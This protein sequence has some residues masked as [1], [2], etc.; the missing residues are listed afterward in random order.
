[1]EVG[2]QSFSCYYWSSVLHLDHEGL[3]GQATY[4]ENSLLLVVE[5][6]AKS[7][8]RQQ[9]GR[10]GNI[11]AI[12]FSQ[13]SLRKHMQTVYFFYQLSYEVSRE[14]AFKGVGLCFF[15]LCS[16]LISI[17]FL[18]SRLLS[19]LISLSLSLSLSLSIY[20]YIYIYDTIASTRS[21]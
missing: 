13:I 11:L 21:F 6:K 5:D 12:S 9:Q 2:A 14:K 19:S 16:S 4:V 15:W 7:H 8:D 3:I 17:S 10:Q 18:Y 20:I 1:M